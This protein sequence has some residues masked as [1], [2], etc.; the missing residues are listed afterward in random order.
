MPALAHIIRRRSHRKRRQ[1]QR[2]RRSALQTIL[3]V[4]LPLTLLA[5]P[6]LALLALSV[7][8]YIG[9]QSIMPSPQQTLLDDSA[10]ITQYTDRHGAALLQTGDGA[11]GNPSRWLALDELPTHLVALSHLVDARES[12]AEPAAFDAL[13]TLAQ[14]SAY[15]LDLPLQ[16]DDSRS[17][18]LAR[19]N[20]LPQAQSSAMDK[21]LLE[22]VFSAEI[23]RTLNEEQL[24]EW[25]LN[26]QSYDGILGVD[27]AAQQFLGK[28]AARLSLA[29]AA[30][31]TAMAAQPPL[32]PVAESSQI[33]ARA[34]ELLRA[35]QSAG[36]IDR[37]QAAIVELESLALRDP[38]TA[39]A[40]LNASFLALAR[41]QA[42]QILERQGLAGRQLFAG[43]GMTITTTLDLALQRRAA[44][45]FATLVMLDARTGEILSLVGDA[46]QATRQPAGILQPFVYMDAFARRTATP[47]TMLYD[48]SRTYPA[49][50][51]EIGYTPANADG[52]ERGPLSL[53]EALAGGLLPPAVQVASQNGIQSAL[54]LAGAL[55]INSLDAQSSD[56]TLLEGGGAVSALDA[57]YAYSVIAA[58][59]E[60]HGAPTVPAGPGLRGRD[61]LAVLRIEDAAGQLLWQYDAAA[62]RSVIIQP[63]LAYLINDILSDDSTRGSSLGSEDEPLPTIAHIR[64]SSAD[65]RDHWLIQYTPD[66]VL[67]A[68]SRS[69]VTSI[70][71]QAVLEWAHQQR[72]LPARDWLAPPD[73]EEFLVCEISGMLPATTDHCP[74]RREIVPA[75]SQL[76]PDDR[77]QSLEINS[78]TGQL[79]SVNTPDHLRATQ[80]YFLPPDE[81]LDWW[82]EHDK[83]L[84][85]DQFSSESSAGPAK[86]ARLL[87]PT[88]FAYVGARVE[89][90]A[91]I[92]RPGALSWRLEYGAEVNP[93]SW[94]PIRESQRIG[95]DGELQAL[96]ETALLSGAHTLRLVVDF[97]DGSQESDSKLLTFDNTP[98]AIALAS[99]ESARAGG[100]RVGDTL[101][102]VADARDNLAIDRVE[103]YR[104]DELLGSDSDWRYSWDVVPAES[105]EVI[106][107]A[108]VFDQVGNRAQATLTI[109]ISE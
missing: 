26:S 31:L 27:G 89:I 93:D 15:I 70:D 100:I 21:R 75:N 109:P 56:L 59:G 2:A 60:M 97:A 45:S 78:A 55:G 92:I 50:A 72:S 87:A 74:V 53:R 12:A 1:K 5:A 106:Y 66:L 13:D 64:A 84:P 17:A 83:P 43:G 69:A 71:S 48:I 62:S 47:A 11:A 73:I 90:Q 103:F 18:Q 7:W 20:L 67:A 57:A 41:A 42:Q 68:H 44:E 35:L 76:L 40:G 14:L 96:W 28:S 95:A 77:W 88:D 79:A 19:A 3:F 37:A 6:P 4:V 51:D 82:R 32:D 52:T 61:P 102:L 25:R 99:S 24:L 9:A 81:I 101:T 46:A 85:P 10:R 105:G 38:S 29:E 49:G 80:A 58:L 54:Q 65:R 33:R 98:P 34:A 39:R 108:L 104:G 23:K 107:R 22:I 94:I 86:A 63:S 16:R 91:K 36:Q 30:F 8:L